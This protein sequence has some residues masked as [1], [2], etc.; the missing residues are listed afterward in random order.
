[1]QRQ[2]VYYIINYI[3][4]YITMGRRKLKEKNIR[5]LLRIGK[6]TGSI[7]V[8]LPKEMVSKLGWRERQK[9]KVKISGRKIVISDWEKK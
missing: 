4:N 5:K 1:L 8:T 9:V 6:K 2:R 3:I 7:A